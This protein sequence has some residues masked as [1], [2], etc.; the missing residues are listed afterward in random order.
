MK[1]PWTKAIKLPIETLEYELRSRLEEAD[2]S[3]DAPL[4]DGCYVINVRLG[5]KQVIIEWLGDHRFR[6]TLISK[7][8]DINPCPEE[9]TQSI[10][11]TILRVQQL[12]GALI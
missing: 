9:L 3:R 8:H 11:A 7:N 10:N 1:T 2:I 6:T 5:E 12:L 4:G